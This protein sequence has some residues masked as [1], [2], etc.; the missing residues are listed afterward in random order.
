MEDERERKT[1]RE[2]REREREKPDLGWDD[3]GVQGVVDFSRG[4]QDLSA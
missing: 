4:W 3:A 2:K 1:Q